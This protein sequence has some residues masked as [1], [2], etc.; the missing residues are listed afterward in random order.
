[1]KKVLLITFFLF[2]L[3][4]LYSQTQFSWSE[5]YPNFSSFKEIDQG[6]GIKARVVFIKNSAAYG[7][8]IQFLNPT[9]LPL[10]F[11]YT[12]SNSG[13]SCHNTL[14]LLPQN[15]STN[16]ATCGGWGEDIF[17]VITGDSFVITRSKKH[18][19]QPQAKKSN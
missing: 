7:F 11:G 4:D 10:R 16:I 5:C 2:R 3:S 19:T 17:V 14:F 1:M 13:G 9:H 12:N 18:H 8:F 15:V 6:L